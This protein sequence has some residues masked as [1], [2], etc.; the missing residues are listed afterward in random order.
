M[1]S[2]GTM[3]LPFAGLIA[4]HG[5]AKLSTDYMFRIRAW[6][7]SS[8]TAEGEA[9]QFSAFVMLYTGMLK[10]VKFGLHK[11]PPSYLRAVVSK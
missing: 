2:K 10:W 11:F 6:A 5:N 8:S 9:V 3:Q 7:F 1:R 4:G